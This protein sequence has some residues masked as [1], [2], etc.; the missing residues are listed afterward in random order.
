MAQKATFI[1]T[2]RNSNIHTAQSL[3]LNLKAVIGGE[4]T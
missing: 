4:I 3:G 2:L 1:I